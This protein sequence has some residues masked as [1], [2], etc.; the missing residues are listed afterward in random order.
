MYHNLFLCFHSFFLYFILDNCFLSFSFQSSILSST[1]SNM[2]F[3]SLKHSI[4]FTVHL[5]IIDVYVFMCALCVCDCGPMCHSAPMMVQRIT[6]WNW[7][8]SSTFILPEFWKWNSGCQLA[9]QM[10]LPAESSH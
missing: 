2:M 10:P 4:L 6:L 5:F 8:S 3:L 1:M 9:H 7:F